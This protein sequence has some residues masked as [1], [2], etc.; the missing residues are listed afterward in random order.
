MIGP[1]EDRK[2]AFEDHMEAQ[3]TARVSVKE[4]GKIPDFVKERVKETQKK[5]E[6]ARKDD[7]S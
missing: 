2:K 6:D 5:W 1:K 7:K 3:E 4:T